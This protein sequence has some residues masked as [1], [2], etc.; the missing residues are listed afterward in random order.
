MTHEQKLK[1]ALQE[2]DALKSK[3]EGLMKPELEVGKW[4]KGTVDFESFIF[5]TEI[6]NVDSY[7]SYNRIHGYGFISGEWNYLSHLFSNTEHE[8]SLV[9][10]TPQEVEEALVKEAKRRGLLHG[11]RFISPNCEN[12]G[13]KV[14]SNDFH[15]DSVNNTLSFTQDLGGTVFLF[16]HGH[17][18]EPIIEQDKFAE[19]KEAHR[20]GAVI[21]YFCIFRKKWEIATTPCWDTDTEYRI[22]PEEEPNVGDIVKVWDAKEGKFF[23]GTLYKKG[24]YDVPYP[25][26]VK[27]YNSRDDYNFYGNAEKIT[28]QEA[29]ELLFGKQNL[30]DDI[31]ELKDKHPN[32]RFT[33]TA[34]DNR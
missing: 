4:Y 19:L 31:Q 25:F 8:E 10:A 6:E 11:V 24:I 20:N 12:W 5:I 7:D 2:L 15:F 18:A 26:M 21:E 27:L 16:I 30:A 28:K 34:E 3:I 9:E 13:F 32:L 14:T 23:I 22:K 1:Q 33:I 17:W 29:I